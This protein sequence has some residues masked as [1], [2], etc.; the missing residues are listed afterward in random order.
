MS[1]TLEIVASDLVTVTGGA[2]GLTAAGT[3]V[4]SLLGGEP[5]PEINR[6]SASSP[7]AIVRTMDPI[8]P[9]VPFRIR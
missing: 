5:L 3:A 4:L 7:S 2:G 8:K 1:N 6:P 9:L